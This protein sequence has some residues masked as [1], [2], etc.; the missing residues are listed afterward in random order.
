MTNPWFRMYHEFATDPKVQMLSEV[1]QRR[2]V[3]LLC[4]RCCNGD[5]TLHETE[6][7]FQLRISDA[8]LAETKATLM[9]KNLVDDDLKPLA[10]DKR[11]FASDSSTARVREY[12]E[13]QKELQE[14]GCNVTETPPD[15]DTDTE[16]ICQ[17][18]ENLWKS[19]PKDMGEKGVK[20]KALKCWRREVKTRDLAD[21]ITVLRDTQVASKRERRKAGEFS[22]NFPH[23]E[24][25]I[26]DK[27]WNDE[28]PT[29]E[30]P[31]RRPML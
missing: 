16:Y 17:V 12:R 1:D 29:S 26:R 4:L 28:M 9:A 30:Q 3:M 19:W 24:R 15:T 7:A 27:R 13:R 11:Q 5:E 22:P 8:E 2:F 6:V 25:W 10:W 21:R 31:A 20:H 23:V 14:Q 18:F